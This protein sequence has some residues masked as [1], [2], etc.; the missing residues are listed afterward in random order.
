MMDLADTVVNDPLTVTQVAVS[1][2]SAAISYTI[3]QNLLQRLASASL[4]LRINIK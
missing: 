3:H 4:S 2:E 1:S